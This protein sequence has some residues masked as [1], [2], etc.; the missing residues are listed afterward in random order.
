M[1]CGASGGSCGVY[2]FCMRRQCPSR[3]D[4]TLRAQVKERVRLVKE[5]A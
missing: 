1:N 4:L 5:D 3:V 2:G